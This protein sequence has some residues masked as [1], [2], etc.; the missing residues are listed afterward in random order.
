MQALLPQLTQAYE[1]AQ[2]TAPGAPDVDH[3]M[4]RLHRALLDEER[5]LQYQERALTH[6]PDFAPALYE[7][8]VLLSRRYGRLRESRAAFGD[9][10][11]TEPAELVRLRDQ[12]LADGR[13]LQTMRLE[14]TSALAVRGLIAHHDGRG[15]QAR[16]LLR[17]ALSRDPAREEIWETLGAEEERRQAWEAAEAVYN[18]GLSRDRGY[19]PLLLGRCRVYSRWGRGRTQ[20]I[21]DATAVIKAT[22]HL[23]EAWLCRAT[24]RAY[25]ANAAAW[26][27]AASRQLFQQAEA[28]FS[29]ALAR[30]PRNADTLWARG[31]LYRYRASAASRHGRDPLPDLQKAL[32]D[33][34]RAAELVPDR[35]SFQ[36][37]LARVKTLLGAAEAER[38]G[39]PELLFKE[40]EAAFAGALA[41]EPARPDALEWQG[42]LLAHWAVWRRQDR[43][44]AEAL[45]ERAESSF[46]RSLELF[47]TNRWAYFH[48]GRARLW[49]GDVG[50]EEVHWRAA[51][52]DLDQ[53][54]QQLG[55]VPDSWLERASAKERLASRVRGREKAALLQAARADRQRAAAIDPC[56]VR[57]F[58]DTSPPQECVTR[59][60]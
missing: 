6:A 36:A 10:D 53:A 34:R 47:R 49:R 18:Q 19:L 33:L 35:V 41:R 46:S 7:R 14:E 51:L 9:V 13:R 20:A 38:G 56:V 30:A 11:A 29:A 28:D 57:P 60:L 39:D 37:G 59:P 44:I 1:R 42:D 32:A 24:C 26:R 55:D 12:V 16:A 4:G 45:F 52:S 27:G 15:E 21:A 23:V 58:E 17:Q 8:A 2:R 48:R 31:A 22:P 54:V 50:G 25:E 3:L 40:A 5:A 43:A